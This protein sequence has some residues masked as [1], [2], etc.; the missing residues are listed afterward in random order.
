MENKRFNIFLNLSSSD[1]DSEPL[2]GEHYL[3]VFDG[4]GG[5]G[6]TFVTNKD[7][8][9]QANAWYASRFTQSILKDIFKKF[10]NARCEGKSFKEQLTKEDIN[11]IEILI[12]E[13]LHQKVL[14][15]GLS[16]ENVR[17]SLLKRLP[18]TMCS[19]YFDWDNDFVY[20]HS[21]NVGDSRLYCLSKQKDC[22]Y[23]LSQLSLDSSVDLLDGMDSLYASEK[24][25]M[26]GDS[27]IH[28]SDNKDEILFSIEYRMFKI[29][30]PAVVFACSD[31]VYY[32]LDS[33]MHLEYMILASLIN[34][35]DENQFK[36]LLTYAIDERKNDDRTLALAYFPGKVFF[37]NENFNSLKGSY[38]KYYSNIRKKN[39][40]YD[41][42]CASLKDAYVELFNKKKDSIIEFI[43]QALEIIPNIDLEKENINRTPKNRITNFYKKNI[44]RLHDYILDVN[45]E[46]DAFD[47]MNYLFKIK[48]N[49]YPSA[50][51]SLFDKLLEGFTINKMYKEMV[52]DF[53]RNNWWEDGYKYSYERYYKK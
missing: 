17:G 13:G 16:F 4:L 12:N 23:L 37:G 53:L 6:A 1:Q 28:I 49:Q 46:E 8:F 42:Y 48:D 39:N 38:K 26:M 18:T 43:N 9:V 24:E 25:T 5:A 27:I 35:K 30:K 51:K 3:G 29:P 40:E 22:K 14:D 21:F 44:S 33:P 20:V 19:C 7:G 32:Y 36:E 11:G 15:E 50:I 31:G 2:I 52:R 47:F 41:T 10:D 34:A 45:S